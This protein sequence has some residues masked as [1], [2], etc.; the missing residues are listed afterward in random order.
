MV[1]RAKFVLTEWKNHVGSRRR[2]GK[3]ER[4]IMTSLIF[5]PVAGDTEENEKFWDATPLGKIELGIVNPE[6]VKEFEIL[7]EYY[8]DFTPAP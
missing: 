8:V 7:K 5:E 2:N 3:W 1:V 4:A 6:A